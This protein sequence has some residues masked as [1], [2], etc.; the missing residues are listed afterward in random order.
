[1]TMCHHCH[2]QDNGRKSMKLGKHQSHQSK[3][4]L[5][6]MVNMLTK[7]MN[8]NNHLN[9]LMSTEEGKSPKY[10]IYTCK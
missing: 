6:D 5:P 2:Q 1:M 4:Y 9:S 10:Y 7:M 3:Y 8:S